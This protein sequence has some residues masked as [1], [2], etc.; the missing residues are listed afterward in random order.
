MND[1]LQARATAAGGILVAL[2]GFSWVT[3]SRPAPPVVFGAGVIALGAV[4]AARVNNAA[5]PQA[6]RV[7]SRR[8][9][10]IKWSLMPV[11]AA[12]ATVDGTERLPFTATAFALAVVTVADW[13]RGGRVGISRPLA[14][15]VLVLAGLSPLF[16]WADRGVPG[17]GLTIMAAIGVTLMC[18]GPLDLRPAAPLPL[19][20]AAAFSQPV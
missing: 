1:P 10:V 20:S 5:D 2:G 8:S 11:L 14:V 19:D 6:P 7:A 15:G 12:I 17:M 18:G 4:L 9:T 13:L 3:M 16:G